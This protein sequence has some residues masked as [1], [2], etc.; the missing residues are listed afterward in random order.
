[1]AVGK[2]GALL[3]GGLAAVAGAV[4]ATWKAAARRAAWS[5]E[6]D[7]PAGLA[8]PPGFRFG[9]ATSAHQVE[10]GTTGNNWTR[11][12]EHLRPDGRRGVYSGEHC[13]RAVD[14]WER[15]EDDVELMSDLGI[16]MYRFSLEWSRLEPRPGA[17]DDVALERYRAWCVLLREAGIAPM[18]TL[19]HFTEPLWLTDRGGFAD[20]AAV[21]AFARLV[22]HVAPVLG[23]VCDW[24][25]TVNEPE[26]FAFHGWLRGEFP[27]GETDAARTGQV[28]EHVLLAHARAYHLLHQLATRDADGDGVPCRVSLA[29]NVMPTQP[30][31]PWNPADVA[32]ARALHTAYNAAPLDACTDGRFRFGLLGA[33]RRQALHRELAGTLDYIGVNHYSRALVSFDPRVPGRHSTTFDLESEKNDLGWDLLPETLGVAVRFAGRYG[34]PVVVTE[35]GTCDGEVPDRR[36]RAFLLDSLHVLDRCIRDGVDVRGYLH[37]SLLD[38][39]EWAHGFGPRFGLYRVDRATLERTLTSGGDLYRG[40]ITEHRA[41]SGPPPPA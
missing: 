37:W 36:R 21:D 12:E 6:A 10:G 28:L 19:H 25:I 32:A 5:P 16:D 1:M 14:H 40:I 23:E 35:H 34:K 39:F 13:G 27:P 29:K 31:R 30:L 7:A 24:W 2:R 38:N 15:F 20:R 26:V 9:A 33:G 41:R 8:F 4:G 17:F 3:A 18:I 11:W 22:E